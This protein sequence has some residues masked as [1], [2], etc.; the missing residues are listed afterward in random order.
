[1]IMKELIQEIKEHFAAGLNGLR[2]IVSLP[3]DYS[4][5]TYRNAGIYGLAIELPDETE[6]NEAAN[7]VI[8]ST[9]TLLK[10][11]GEQNFLLLTCLDEEYRNEFAELSY[12]FVD[13]GVNGEKRKALL[14]DPILWWNRWTEL[15]GDRK[16]R[17]GSYDVL[18][19]MIALDYLY[20]QDKT[21]R[22]SAS[23]AGT[24]DIESDS[25]SYEIKSTT[26]KSE[27]HIT[28]SSRFQLE[29]S[30]KLELFFFR[31][32][33]SQSGF[34]INDVVESL[35][36]HG[37]D[38]NLIESQLEAKGFVK[39]RCTRNIKYS[40]L[41]VRRFDVDD[42]FPKIVEKS[43]KDNVFP[44][45]IIKILYTIDLEGIDYTSLNFI[46]N[47]DH[48][49]SAT[50]VEG[51]E[52][53]SG[54]KNSPDI[55][56]NESVEI[57][58]FSEYEKGR[59]PLYSL[60]AACGYFEDGEMPEAEGWVEATGHGFTPDPKRHFAVHAKGDSMYPKINNG[61][62]CVFEWYQAGS[63]NG[64]I[65]LTQS[66]EFDSEYGGKYTIKK[67]YSEK[68]STEEGWQNMKIELKPINP[69]FCP[70]EL[71]EDGNYRT[72]G[73]LKCVL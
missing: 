4:A 39:G 46:K 49:I 14:K 6:I 41:E 68:K 11:S 73:I 13:P 2:R 28:I 1:M 18:A 57:P 36:R 23:E 54:D 60:R 37:Y 3:D 40:I 56:I 70:I 66:N 16:S 15:L 63:R 17:K 35:E 61:D 38:R 32:E 34:S 42:K 69:D 27:S 7:E 43:F 5:Y 24:H 72:I 33:C 47:E 31:L 8:Y 10:E 65:V 53:K 55:D 62:I 59:I 67:Y 12:S 30:N 58:I 52:D 29:C 26:K 25:Q 50:I 44:K 9:Q 22:W 48:T 21:I 19:E 20:Q 45:N 51:K 64:E 71:D